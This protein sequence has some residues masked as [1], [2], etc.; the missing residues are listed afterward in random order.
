MNWAPGHARCTAEP[1]LLVPVPA[2]GGA[3]I[4]DR[5]CEVH[6]RATATGACERWAEN[7]RCTAESRLLV[8][9][10]V[11]P[12]PGSRMRYTVQLSRG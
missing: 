10:A 12:Y 1:R 9:R 2:S 6:S 11:G 5:E 7:A 8:L 3:H 4:L